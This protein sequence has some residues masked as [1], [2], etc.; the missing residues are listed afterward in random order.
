ML[1]L[2]FK[3]IGAINTAV[4]ELLITWLKAVVKRNTPPNNIIG[5][6]DLNM[7]LNY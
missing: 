7:L 6:C 3:A 2:L 4:A 1:E 5:L